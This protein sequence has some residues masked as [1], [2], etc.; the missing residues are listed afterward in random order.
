MLHIDHVRTDRVNYLLAVTRSEATTPFFE[1]DG[2]W[3]PLHRSDGP[4]SSAPSESSE[5]KDTQTETSLTEPSLTEPS[6]TEPSLTEPSQTNLQQSEFV[7]REFSQSKDAILLLAAGRD[8]ISQAE[9][10][11]YAS[12]VRNCAFDVTFAAPKG[13]SLLSVIG[14]AAVTE[15]IHLAH[16]RAV[17]ESLTFASHRL[18][19]VQRRHD[20]VRKTERA[21]A[22]GAS[23][24]LHRV[25]RALDPHLHSHLLLWNLARPV[26]NGHGEWSAIDARPIYRQVGLLGDLYRSALRAHLSDTLRLRWRVVAPGFY[27]IE[28]I[29]PP[30]SAA[31]SRR[32]IAILH[33]LAQ[34]GFSSPAAQ[35]ISAHSSRPR[36]D[37]SCGFDEL[38]GQWRQ[39]AHRVGLSAGRLNDL[40]NRTS[41]RNL[42]VEWEHH[43][44]SFEL[45][46][47]RPLSIELL[48][49][50]ILA[51]SKG[52]VSLSE[53]EEIIAT[54]S[55]R[56][57]ETQ[58]LW[59]F[60]PRGNRHG[61]SCESHL[62]RR[63]V[64]RRAQQR[65]L[66]SLRLLSHGDRWS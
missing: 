58:E 6:L 19:V 46:R 57:I 5:T 42:E 28:G 8:P 11:P 16:R 38:V 60:G 40:C 10:N 44:S 13:L 4:N 20:G 18:F 12:R 56:G 34:R 62:E 27:D 29:E 53:L 36:R 17:M 14:E 3:I 63:R 30:M 45:S 37:L 41:Q 48:C 64:A 61:R 21:E 59:P 1:D 54:L 51:N 25:S 23:E 33:D 49:R 2:H 15:A 39:R 22:Y 52:G 55:A 43:L 50:K 26:D 7:Q 66:E 9:L 32:S 31:F 35:R 24:F 65:S 47:E